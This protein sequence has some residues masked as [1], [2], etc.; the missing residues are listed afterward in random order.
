[1]EDEWDGTVTLEGYRYRNEWLE[2]VWL[3]FLTGGI[4]GRGR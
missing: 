4:P 2:R 3:D 1:M